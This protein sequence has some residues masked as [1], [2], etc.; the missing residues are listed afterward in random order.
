M[1][2]NNAN[3]NNNNHSIRN[4]RSLYPEEL[5]QLRNIITAIDTELEYNLL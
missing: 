5:Q 3:I 2:N 1:N 4:S